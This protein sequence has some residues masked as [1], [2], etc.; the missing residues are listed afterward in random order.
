DSNFSTYQ[1]MWHFMETAKAPN[2]VFTKSNVEGVNRVVK[3]KGNYAFLM[4]STSIEYV[5]E[6]NCELTQIGGLLDS[7]GYG[8]AMPPNSP[9]R[10]AISGAILKLQEEGKLH[11]LKTKWWKEK[12]GGGSCRVRY[13]H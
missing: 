9:Y 11:I 5:I 1:R 8:I 4:E 2:E 10:T 12:H 13:T 6:R 7:K 3:G